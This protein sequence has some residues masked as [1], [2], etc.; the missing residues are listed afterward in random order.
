MMAEKKIDTVIDGMV[1]SIP[2]ED[3]TPDDSVVPVY[4]IPLTDDEI[5]ISE[6]SMKDKIDRDVAEKA[7]QNARESALAK[8]KEIA[9]LDE[10]EVEALLG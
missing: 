1:Q 3:I 4:L 10:S 2:G 6:Q 5:T 7:K 9:G 8:L